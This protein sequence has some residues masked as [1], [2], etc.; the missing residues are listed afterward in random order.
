LEAQPVP[1]DRL[2]ITDAQDVVNVVQDYV[3][4][5]GLASQAPGS[6]L[7]TNNTASQA[8]E[9]ANSALAQVQTLSGQIPQ[10][11]AS[12][13]STPIALA[14]GDSVMSFTWSD[15]MPDNNYEVRVVFFGP[16]GAVANFAWH[17]QDASRTSNSVLLRFDNI[18]AGLSAIFIAEQVL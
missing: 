11:R 3:R 13:P 15:A 12:N 8:L 6:T 5:V 14:V 7:T 2:C 9:T 17:V 10:R 4:V 1:E 16:A 18:P